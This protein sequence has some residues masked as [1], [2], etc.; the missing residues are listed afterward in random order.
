MFR[1]IV[2][3]ELD[4]LRDGELTALF[5]KTQSALVTSEPDSAE[6]RNILA[7]MQNISRALRHRA[8]TPKP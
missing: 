5:A 8:L 2:N 3:S 4:R 1:L 7:S 6:R